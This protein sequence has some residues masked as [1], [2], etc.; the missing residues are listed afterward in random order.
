MNRTPTLSST[1]TAAGV[2]LCMGVLGACSGSSPAAEDTEA[3]TT[4][5]R[6][7]SVLESG[8]LKVC[9][10]GDYR[11]YSYLDP[12][13]QEYEGIDITMVEDLASR[14]DVKVDYVQTTWPNL[15]QDFLDQCDIAVGGITVSTDR[16]AIAYFSSAT[17]EDGKTPITLCTDVDK[18]DTIDEINRAGVRSI[19]PPGATNEKFA[20]A[21]YPNGEIIRFADNNAIFDEI[22]A[23]RADVMTTDAS[24]T[25]W[26]QNEHPELCAVHPDN[27]FTHTQKAYMLPRGDGVMQQYVDSWLSIAERDGTFDAAKKPWWG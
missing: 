23:G 10:T 14:M 6:L 13:T 2:V 1:L 22:I 17:V 25:L 24:E 20:E 21:N 3:S 27:P 12:S 8:T 4:T 16:A 5:S 19:T 18:Y 7:D 11:P 26:V 15:S 9:T